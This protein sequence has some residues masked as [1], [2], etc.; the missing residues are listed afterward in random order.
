MNDILGTED[1]KLVTGY[2]RAG[3]V[4]KCLQDQGVKFFYGKGGPWTTLDLIN[5]AGGLTKLSH[6]ETEEII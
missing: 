4:E 3:D 5:A 2:V 1:L 6:D